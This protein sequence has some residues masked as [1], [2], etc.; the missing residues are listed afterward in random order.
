MRFPGQ[1]TER[2]SRSSIPPHSL[3][4][5]MGPWFRPRKSCS[6]RAAEIGDGKVWYRP[7]ERSYIRYS[8]QKLEI[9]EAAIAVK[10][11]MY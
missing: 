9:I 3:K 2:V 5:A 7:A 6:T 10:R 11:E 1:E 4:P 8:S